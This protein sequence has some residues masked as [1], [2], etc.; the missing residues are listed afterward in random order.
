MKKILVIGSCGSGKSTLAK[1]LS[2]KL[3]LPLVNLDQHYWR[4]GWIR[5]EKNEWREKVLELI[6]E[7]NWIMDGNYQSTLDIRMPASD[8]IIFVDVNR[9]ICFWRICKRRTL[10][11]R[12]DEINGCKEKIDLQLIWWALWEYPENRRPKV[13]ELLKSFSDKEIII[14]KTGQDVKNLLDK[15]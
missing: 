3:N 11:N 14:V 15:Y 6:K 8:T 1:E 5:L 13:L 2:R 4:P 10:K 12:V 7:D 9:F